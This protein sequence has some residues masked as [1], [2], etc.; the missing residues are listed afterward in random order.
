[1][2]SEFRREGGVP[3]IWT[4]LHNGYYIKFGKGGRE[5]FK[6]APNIQTSHSE[7]LK[8]SMHSL[9]ILAFYESDGPKVYFHVVQETPIC[10][11]FHFLSILNP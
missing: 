3:E 2:M 8:G 6:N 10:I 1:M 11:F 7:L 9:G 4:L 5:G